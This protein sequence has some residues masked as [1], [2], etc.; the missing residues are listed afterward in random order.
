MRKVILVRL[1]SLRYWDNY[2][3]KKHSK[4]GERILKENKELIRFRAIKIM[5]AILCL[6]YTKNNNKLK[7]Y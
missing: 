6:R 2:D 3:K 7:K 4:K 5:Q 1:I